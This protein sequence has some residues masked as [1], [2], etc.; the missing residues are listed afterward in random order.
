MI[1]K[2][3]PLLEIIIDAV[4]HMDYDQQKHIFNVI[5]RMD[6][7]QEPHFDNFFHVD[8]KADK[9][10]LSEWLHRKLEIFNMS[11]T[12]LSRKSGLSK[13]SINYYLNGKVFP[14]KRQ[15]EKLVQVFNDNEKS[16]KEN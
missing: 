15:F 11:V 14:H 7:A 4:T 12:E 9:K 5:Q 8:N 1:K 2:D 3:I 10:V 6:G 16:S 13:G